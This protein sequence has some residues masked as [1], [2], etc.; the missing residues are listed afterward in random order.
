MRVLKRYLSLFIVCVLTSF[1]GAQTAFNVAYHDKSENVA[2]ATSN[3]IELFGDYYFT[4][5]NYNAENYDQLNLYKISSNGSFKFKKVIQL[6]FATRKLARTLDNKII[7]IGGENLCDVPPPNPRNFICKIDTSGTI[8]FTNSIADILPNISK[9]VVQ[10][11]DSTYSVFTDSVLYRY[12]KNGAFIQRKNTGLKEISSA[13]LHPNGDILLS[14]K[15]NSVIVISKMN[16][17]GVITGSITVSIL[18]NKMT[19]YNTNQVIGVG[20]DGKLYKLT[21]SLVQTGISNF[22]FG[23]TVTDLVIDNDS[24][25]CISSNTVQSYLI[26][27]TTFSLINFNGGIS[28]GFIQSTIIKKENKVAILSQALSKTSPSWPGYHTYITLNV[29]DKMASNDYSRDIEVVSVTADSSYALGSVPTNTMGPTMYFVFLRAKVKVKNKGNSM[30]TNFNL[31]M[32]KNPHVACG[33]FY[34]QEKF[35][36]TSVSPGDT[37][38]VM[39][40]FLTKTIYTTGPLQPSVTQSICIFATVPNGEADKYYEDNELCKTFTVMVNDVSLKENKVE[41]N[42]VNIYPNPFSS[43]LNIESKESI[44]NIVL[45]DQLGRI[46]FSKAVAAK[47]TEFELKEIENGIY[48]LKIETEKGTAIKKVIRN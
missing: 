43:K 24:L 21:S 3:L 37:V 13:L 9:N 34:Y 44:K 4:T 32:Y 27:D 42:I 23:A 30:L 20:T 22:A 16:S 36:V 47:N 17:A 15:S 2:Y 46:I 25:Y 10:Y 12:D 1:L 19:L 14:A 28:N 45:S 33:S 35:N 40:P 18:F 6:P 41:N 26:S 29:I 7:L 31:N 5:K 48:F 11:S 39:T 38:E 8:S